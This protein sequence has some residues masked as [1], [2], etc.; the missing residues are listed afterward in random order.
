VEEAL[1]RGPGWKRRQ[2]RGQPLPFCRQNS[3]HLSGN[4]SDVPSG[5]EQGASPPRKAANWQTGGKGDGVPGLEFSLAEQRCVRGSGLTVSVRPR[6]KECRVVDLRPRGEPGDRP[7]D[8]SR[9]RVD[10]ADSQS[11]QWS[12]APPKHTTPMGR[13]SLLVPS[14]LRGSRR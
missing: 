4:M 2:T 13:F 10:S 7:G 9:D 5:T 6:N 11:P 3:P 14:V 8:S 1:T 12:L